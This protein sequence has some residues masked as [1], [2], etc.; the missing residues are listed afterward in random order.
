MTPEGIASLIVIL[1][2]IGLVIFLLIAIKW[3]NKS[4]AKV[5]NKRNAVIYA[6]R[7][8]QIIEESKDIINRSKK[9]DTIKHRFDVTSKITLLDKALLLIVDGKRILKEED[10]VKDLESKEKEIKALIHQIE[11]NEN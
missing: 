4:Q 6:Q 2:V 11:E 10:K 8:V 3:Y 7:L 1:A 5:R 9:L